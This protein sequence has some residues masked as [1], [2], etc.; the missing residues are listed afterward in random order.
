MINIV[1]VDKGGTIKTVKIKDNSRNNLYKKCGIRSDKDFKCHTKWNVTLSGEKHRIELWGRT[2]GK[3]NTENK[4]DFPPPMDNSLFFGTCCLVKVDINTDLLVNLTQEL[5]EKI[6]EKLFGGFEDIEPE[7]EESEDELA[8]VP[9][10]MKTKTGYLKDDFVVDEEEDE[11]DM[12]TDDEEE[13]VVDDNEEEDSEEDD[14]Y[15][16]EEIDEND[17]GDNLQIEEY[18]Y[19]DED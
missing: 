9:K 5:W 11:H 13:I 19:S 3:A 6:Y 17:S 8:S 14:E 12:D 16:S 18:C 10:E 4:Y 2:E 1:L 15:E 7:E